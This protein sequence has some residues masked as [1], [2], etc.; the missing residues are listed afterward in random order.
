MCVL[1]I[2]RI[3]HKT[4]HKEQFGKCIV[5][6][7]HHGFLQLKKIRGSYTFVFVFAFLCITV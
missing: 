5:F 7:F 2:L 6:Q 4:L 3:H 1:I